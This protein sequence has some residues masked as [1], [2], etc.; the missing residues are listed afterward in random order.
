MAEVPEEPRE[1]QGREFASNE[2]ARLP[3]AAA[4][5]LP[6]VETDAELAEAEETIHH[7]AGPDTGEETEE[8]AG[9]EAAAELRLMFAL[10]L[11]IRASG[12]GPRK[13][14]GRWATKPCSSSWPGN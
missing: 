7:H 6:D 5:Q 2:P 11:P 8:E 4:S 14:C 12:N 3:E 13:I 10:R 9:E 1:E